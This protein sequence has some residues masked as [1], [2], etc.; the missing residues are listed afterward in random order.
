MPAGRARRAKFFTTTTALTLST[1]ALR[2]HEG[3]VYVYDLNAW[4]RHDIRVERRTLEQHPEVRRR[5]V[6]GSGARPP[7]DVG[8]L[9]R[10]LEVR[11]KRSEWELLNRLESL[12]ER[13]IE[14]DELRDEVDE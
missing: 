4:W 12:R 10:Y 8:G 5:C 3:F 2:E 9:E 1:F 6:A 11:E 14:L 13:A 7:E